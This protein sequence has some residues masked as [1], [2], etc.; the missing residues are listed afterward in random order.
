MK[1]S[2]IPFK[3]T[4][5]FSKIMI[6]YLEQ[7]ES[8]KEF[9]NNFPDHTGF[10]NQIEEKERSYSK[11]TRL[12]LVAAL[13]KQYANFEV[14]EKTEQHI[15]LLKQKETFTVTTGHQLNLFTGPLYFLYKI[16]S[17][18][19]LA[20][21]LSQ[22]FPNKNVVPM[23]WMA[24]EDHDFDEIN[25]FNFEG[26][27]VKWNRK[28][29]G[30]VGRF[31][32]DGLSAVLDVFAN[33][34]GGSKNAKYLKDLFAKGYLEHSNLADATRYIANDLFKEFGLII[35][36]GD[37][38]SL[39]NVFI[40]FVKDELEH[41][42]SFKEVSKTIHKL[43]TDYKIQVNPREINLFYLGENSRERI[44][45]EDGVFKVNNTSLRFSKSEI[46]RELR[47]NPLA[48]S[49]NVIMRPLFQEVILPNLCY[50]GGAGEMAYWFQLKAY[51]KKVKIPFPILL[52]RNSVQVISEKQQKK[53]DNL[54]ISHA[55]LFAKQHALLSKK[56]TENSEIEVNFEEKM[57]YL[58]NEFSELKAIAKKTDVSFVNAVNAQ[59][60]K[61]LKG[62]EYLQKRLLKAEKKRQKEL[63]DRII[64]LQNELLPNQSLEERQ[65][66]FSEYYI[67]YG[68]SFIQSLKE[69]LKPLDLNFTILEL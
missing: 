8:T 17:T 10:Y 24:T 5:F 67:A 3:S 61:Q 52:L 45:Y 38:A 32:T 27:K 46:L 66:N 23:Y 14:S 11:H 41:S 22:K 21:A 65:L 68:P 19:N 28:D 62:L 9:Y 20:E 34:L 59:E 6:D 44:L 2:S 48:F 35:L 40:P 49:P 29:G 18:I 64:L 57:H 36:D 4:G 37:D 31:S 56:V 47:E 55:E 12:L 33:Q 54:R 60:R 16:I 1:V 50:I 7:K 42:T 30:A 13:K 26:K 51:F 43:E 58:K 25:Y 69:A 53:L 15:E 63:V 39:K